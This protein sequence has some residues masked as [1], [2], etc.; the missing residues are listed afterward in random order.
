MAE[1]RKSTYQIKSNLFKRHEDNPILTPEMWPYEVNSVFNAGAA[2][3]LSGG[4]D[5]QI[6]GVEGAGSSGT[7][8]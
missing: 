3:I 6:T 2:S 7:A 8:I 1:L 5:V 4:G